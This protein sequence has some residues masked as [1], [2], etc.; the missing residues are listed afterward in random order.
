M[1]DFCV[2]FVFTFWKSVVVADFS[3]QVFFFC[4]FN[5]FSIDILA[6]SHFRLHLDADHFLVHGFLEK[7]CYIHVVSV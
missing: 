6:V 4:I 5:G 7:K 1:Y 2:Y 3:L